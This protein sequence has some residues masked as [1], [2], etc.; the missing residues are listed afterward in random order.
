MDDLIGLITGRNLFNF[1]HTINHLLFC[2]DKLAVPGITTAVKEEKETENPDNYFLSQLYYLAEKGYLYEPSLTDPLFKDFLLFFFISQEKIRYE[3]QN[4]G[5][6]VGL[7]EDDYKRSNYWHDFHINIWKRV[8]PLFGI[9]TSIVSTSINKIFNESTKMVDDLFEAEFADIINNDD[10]QKKA[11]SERSKVFNI[12][13]NNIPVPAENIPLNEILDFKELDS[14][15]KRI[16]RIRNWAK[17]I[18]M[19]QLS[20]NEIQDEINELLFEYT[21]HY[22][23]HKLKYNLKR[24]Q[25]IITAFPS[26]IEYLMKMKFSEI[27]KSAFLLKEAELELQEKELGLP[28]KEIAYLY[29]IKKTFQPK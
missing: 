23:I 11:T 24:N 1:K 5:H 8:Y 15:K 12:L 14:T 18:S 26:M 16:N 13:V 25:I 10:N 3:L 20:P 19:K 6:A 27:S 4:N 7:Y 17:K 22:E 21:Q 2:F 29:D 9:E 28:G